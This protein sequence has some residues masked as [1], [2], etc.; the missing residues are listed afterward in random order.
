[1]RTEYLA[2]LRRRLAGRR[3]GNG[4]RDGNARNA[5]RAPREAAGSRTTCEALEGRVLL[6]GDR[7]GTA[8]D[9]NWGGPAHEQTYAFNDQI[10]NNPLGNRDVD[11]WR[12]NLRP[13]DTLNATSTNTGGAL[14][15]VLRLFN[16]NG[17]QLDRVNDPNSNN[18]QIVFQNNSTET[19]TYYVGVSGAPNG[20]YAPATPQADFSAA[21][22]GQYASYVPSDTT[23][24][25]RL[26]LTRTNAAPTV[27]IGS[28]GHGVVLPGAHHF[29]W[30]VG[31]TFLPP[32][33]ITNL[34]IAYNGA[35]VH[36]GPHPHLN[37]AHGFNATSGWAEIRVTASDGVNPPVT[38]SHSFL[39]N[40]PPTAN[41][42]TYAVNEDTTLPAGAANLLSNDGDDG[43]NGGSGLRVHA[44]GRGTAHGGWAEVNANGTF[45]YTPPANF[46]GTDWFDYQI[47]DSY[48]TSGVAS[49]FIVVNPVNDLPSFS[50]GPDVA[51][52]EDA[53]P[54]SVP[55]WAANIS[56]GPANESGQ[57][58][59]F[60]VRNNN[61]A[62]F[63]VQPAIDADGRL[64]FTPAP[65]AFG[66][67]IV[68]VAIHDNGGGAD[69]SAEQ[70][71]TITVNPVNDVPV[72]APDTK[73]GTE[74]V[75][76]SFPA[77]D[78]L[79]NDSAGPA[80][81]SDQ[82]LTVTAV[83]ATANTHGTV[84][85]AN[86]VITYTFEPNYNG[87]ASF[88]YTIHDNGAPALSA[89]SSGTVTINPANDRPVA[90]GT[91]LTTFDDTPVE[92]ALNTLASDVE[93]APLNLAYRI[94]EPPPAF[95]GTLTPTSTGRY[96][97]TPV[98]GFEGEVSFT[99]EVT[100]RGDPDG[101][102][103]NALT[104]LPGT[105]TLRVEERN[106]APLADDNAF[107]TAEDRELL[108]EAPGVL[109]G[110]AD[111]NGDALS[112]ALVPGGGPAHASAFEL[113]PD[114]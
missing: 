100:D 71:F 74:D 2:A 25:Y 50:R 39:V 110:D 113:F 16:V 72:A 77:S 24:N 103:A 68:S 105:V 65:N 66:V 94:V 92:V 91:L 33:A 45:T 10:P 61:N 14:N 78:L 76:L 52:N 114:G 11:L 85:L 13:G 22:S 48:H 101:T 43:V 109:D 49:A 54:Q 53:G 75:T 99:Y 64:T 29:T 104:S 106:H 84:S 58:I 21:T 27:S 60:R 56:R 80:N 5:A 90:G 82:T 7:L 6:T 102:T 95:A 89:S 28:T 46:F 37:N 69:L 17:S 18:A 35:V 36:N 67:A 23:G 73:T 26:N 112:A 41:S 44:G 32:V 57:A 93:T 42:E 3:P 81:E 1:M 4:G 20:N 8:T 55:G 108:V 97:F 34:Y 96:L 38:A 51:V 70:A 88:A 9:V 98:L 59:D 86:G 19:R 63:S 31:D 111:P 62:L 79:A 47:H 87:P 15:T 12:F 40:A 107:T 83:A 30:N